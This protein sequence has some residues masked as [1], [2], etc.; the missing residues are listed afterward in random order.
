MYTSKAEDHNVKQ[1]LKKIEEIEEKEEEEEKEGWLNQNI[2]QIFGE[3]VRLNGVVELNYEYLDVKDIDDEDSGSS[4]DFFLSTAELALRV[5]F[6]EWSKSK[7]VVAA[8]DVGQ[9][10]EDSKIRLDEAIVTLKSL[11]MPLYFIG[12]KTVMPFGVFEDHLIEGTLTEDLYEID[13]WGVTLGF[14]PDFYGLEISFS[15]YKAPQVIENLQNFDTHDF[16]SGRQKEDKFRSY[17][18]NITFEPLEDTLTLS[19]FYD[20]EPGDGS[21]NQSIGGA[22]TLNYWKFTL[23]AEYITA[24]QREKGEN[25]EENKESAGVVGLAFDLLDSLQLATRYEVFDDDTPGDQDEVLDYRF[26]AGFNYS[27]IDVF[28]FPFLEDAIF[29]FE[30]RFSKYEKEKDSEAADSQNMFQ[31]QIA[32]EF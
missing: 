30:Y 31:F 23:D 28:D 12:G 10:G 11:R 19:A 5:F 3:K 20:N 15:V 14:N 25:E 6:N 1:Q 13:E 22:F 9:K 26:I 29:S 17:I 16:R 24:L 18:A 7:I 21:R 4:S 27:F 8:E 32:L 2:Q